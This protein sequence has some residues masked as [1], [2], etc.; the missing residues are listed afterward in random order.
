[1][2]RLPHIALLFAAALLV[3]ADK[4]DGKPKE[5]PPTAKQLQTWI[6]QLGDD[7][8]KVREE[9]TRNLI[10]AGGAAFEAV[11]KATKS[12]DAEGRQR[13]LMIIMKVQ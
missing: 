1:M 10:E 11:R 12:E 8:Y 9:A 5:A 13:A 7:E 2:N 4:N 6:K 3:A